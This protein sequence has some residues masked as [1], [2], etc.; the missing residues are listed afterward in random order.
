MFPDAEDVGL[1]LLEHIAPTVQSTGPEFTP[2][3]IQVRRVGG[4][5]TQ[6]QDRP[7]LEI[8]SFGTDYPNAKVISSA[9]REAMLT[10]GGTSVANVA[11]YPKGVFIDKVIE[12]APPR[13]LTWEDPSKRRKTAAFQLTYRRQSGA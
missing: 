5:A 2:P 10:A 13:E 7:V 6:L 4:V 9:V 11:G 8:A 12:T 3:L 1:A